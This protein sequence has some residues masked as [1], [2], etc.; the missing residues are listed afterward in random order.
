[1]TARLMMQMVEKTGFEPAKIA[2]TWA[3]PAG[4]PLV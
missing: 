2:M 3:L 4:S 1:M